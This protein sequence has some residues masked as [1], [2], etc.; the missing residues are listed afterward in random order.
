AS[1]HVLDVGCG[2]KPYLELFPN[3]STYVGCDVRTSSHDH[4]LSRV[5]RF[6]DGQTLPFGDAS[7]DWVV[8]FETL[9]HV[10]EPEAMLREF[11][12]VTRPE[13]MLL[14]TVPFCW[15]EHEIPNDFGRYTSFG[16]THVLNKNGW[17][18]VRYIKTGTYVLALSQLFMAYLAQ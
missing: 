17:R 5:D 8:S 15:D 6:Y 4:A 1:G 18:V 12:R 16:L 10:F 9:E 2:S 14:L 7:F 13:G 11:H 3:A